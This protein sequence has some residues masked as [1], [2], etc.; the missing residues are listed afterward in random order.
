MKDVNQAIPFEKQYKPFTDKQRESVNEKIKTVAGNERLT[1]KL[2]DEIMPAIVGAVIGGDNIAIV[3]RTLKALRG[4]RR[5][6]AESF[7]PKFVPHEFKNDG[8]FGKRLEKPKA[9]AKVRAFRKWEATGELYSEWGTKNVEVKVKET[10]YGA[11]IQRD[12]KK[13]IE[14]GGFSA[15]QVLA[16]VQAALEPEQEEAQAA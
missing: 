7:L 8:T 5:K 4:E 14:K 3:N 2:L 1:V 13:A 11:L 10:D 16:I 6:V 15:E 9:Q 12:I